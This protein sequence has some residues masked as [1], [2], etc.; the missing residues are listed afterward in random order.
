[1][2]PISQER[3][4]SNLESSQSIHKSPR[5]KE[6]GQRMPVQGMLRGKPRPSRCSH[7]QGGTGNFS[8]PQKKISWP[9]LLKPNGNA[10]GEQTVRWQPHTSARVTLRLKI[11]DGRWPQT[12]WVSLVPPPLP[13]P[14][15]T[16][17]ALLL[18]TARAG[19]FKQTF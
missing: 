3:E 4:I 15:S 9:T 1:M 11:P 12:D 18:P 2:S 6:R 14:P 5:L 13:S 10:Q 17:A 7:P 8:P 16:H 19:V